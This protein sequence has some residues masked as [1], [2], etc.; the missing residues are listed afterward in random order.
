MGAGLEGRVADAFRGGP[1]GD[2]GPQMGL[3]A[4][5][6]VE[7]DV[8]DTRVAVG[9]FG[10][11]ETTLASIRASTLNTV[12]RVMRVIVARFLHCFAIADAEQVKNSV[13]T[14]A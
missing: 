9:L 12:L 5:D 6:E 8:A 1:V 14:E 2:G 10:A 11:A 3:L 7:H 13:Q 4:G